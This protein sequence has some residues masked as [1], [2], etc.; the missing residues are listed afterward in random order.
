MEVVDW[1]RRAICVAAWFAKVCWTV[2]S[3][4]YKVLEDLPS[5]SLSPDHATVLDQCRKLP[6]SWITEPENSD[7]LFSPNDA[8]ASPVGSTPWS[9]PCSP[10][11]L[12]P[13][14]LGKQ[15]GVSQRRKKSEPQSPAPLQ[16][17]SLAPSSLTA[18]ISSPK[19][20]RSKVRATPG[21]SGS[22]LL[23]SPP[24]KGLHSVNPKQ[25]DVA[26]PAR[27]LEVEENGVNV[28]TTDTERTRVLRSVSAKPAG[29]TLRA[30]WSPMATTDPTPATLSVPKSPH[31]LSTPK[32]L[33]R[34]SVSR[35]EATA[36]VPAL[37]FTFPTP[38][39]QIRSITTIDQ[40][41]LHTN[42]SP[43]VAAPNSNEPILQSGTGAARQAGVSTTGGMG[44]KFLLFQ[45]VLIVPQWVI[46]LMCSI[47]Q[48]DRLP[49]KGS[50]IP[51]SV[52]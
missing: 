12:P 24:R 52:L 1:N 7:P 14:Q 8:P 48:H 26:A 33:L 40:D 47:F 50:N 25:I 37:T 10:E 6:G 17:V 39:Q 42:W 27:G 46:L 22:S 4:T 28:A 23:S 45:F 15:M 21:L 51:H 18:R 32:G 35:Q 31:F 44:L 19:S 30:R 36:Q 43:S 49:P 2:I 29:P 16:S 41:L 38:P 34:A 11:S 9:T 20:P 13:P 5:P 3:A